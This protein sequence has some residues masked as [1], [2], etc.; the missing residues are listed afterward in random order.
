MLQP[1]SE[2][3]DPKLPRAERKAERD[4]MRANWTMPGLAT[5]DRPVMSPVRRAG[6]LILGVYLVLA[7]VPV[8]V[9]IIDASIVV[10][11]ASL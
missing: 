6:L 1:A 2:S 8:I 11:A 7:C 9:N 4:A 10:P 5:L 3:G